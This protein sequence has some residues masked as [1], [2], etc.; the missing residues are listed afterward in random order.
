MI[1]QLLTLTDA[2]SDCIPLH[3]TDTQV[4]ACPGCGAQLTSA[5][6][7][8]TSAESVLDHGDECTEMAKVRAAERERIAALAES[9]HA[10]CA[11][12]THPPGGG[13]GSVL[14]Q[15]GRPFADLIRE[16]P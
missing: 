2:P 12:R 13:L 8:G 4:W 16:Q 7:H 14:V 3:W 6:L 1:T 10:T 5:D 15:T 11:G 9:V